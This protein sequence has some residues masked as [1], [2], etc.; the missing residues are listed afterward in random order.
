MAELPQ[1]LMPS[2]L[3]RL[4]DPD[5]A[6]TEARR[7]YGLGQMF[8]VIRRDLEDLLNTRVSLEDVPKGLVRLRESM[9]AFGLPDLTS[10]T[11]ITPQQRDEMA[12]TLERIVAQH[13]PRLRD[14]RVRLT[15]STDGNR[16]VIRCRIEGRF[17]LDPAPEVSFEAMMEPTTGQH[18]VRRQET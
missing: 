11:V 15:E 7:G 1:G 16:P 10:F 13:E 18:K 6:G 4:I 12:G 9:F 3:D 5:S 2:I 14:V 17:A 8:D